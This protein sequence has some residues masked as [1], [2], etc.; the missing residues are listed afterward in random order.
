MTL[1]GRILNAGFQQHNI[2]ASIALAADSFRG[3]GVGGVVVVVARAE[4]E[5]AGGGEYRTIGI[6]R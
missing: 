6:V 1:V 2:L 4:D 5:G 3:I